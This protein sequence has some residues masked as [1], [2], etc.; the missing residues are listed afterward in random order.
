MIR[1]NEPT[2]RRTNKQGRK[3][4]SNTSCEFNETHSTTERTDKGG[5]ENR[6]TLL[7]N[8]GTLLPPVLS[9]FPSPTKIVVG[10][11]CCT[12]SVRFRLRRP[13]QDGSLRYKAANS[14]FSCACP[15]RLDSIS[16]TYFR[17]SFRALSVVK[18]ASSNS[19]VIVVLLL[20]LSAVRCATTIED[21]KER[22]FCLSLST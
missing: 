12:G 5:K 9:L 11:N 13:A 15:R 10:G 22:H 3:T 8:Y 1:T 2:T 21:T 6:R 17:K 16:A 7:T 19:L 20:F 18:T 14:A 4:P